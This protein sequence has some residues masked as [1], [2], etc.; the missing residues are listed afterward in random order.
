MKK[1]IAL[2]VLILITLSAAN[3]RPIIVAH[4]CGGGLAP[5]NTVIA[6]ENAW[7]AGADGIEIDV[8]VTKDG[9]AV[10]LHDNTLE[11]YA[12]ID[13]KVEDATFGQL[14]SIDLGPYFGPQ[15]KNLKIPTLQEILKTVPKG[16]FAE[17]DMKARG[18]RTAE[19][20]SACVL[21][22]NAV[23]RVIIHTDAD[24]MRCFKA[25]MPTVKC[26]GG[27]HPWNIDSEKQLTEEL[28]YLCS[29]FNG[30]A[31]D[32][33]LATKAAEAGLKTWAWTIDDLDRAKLLVK[34][35]VSGIITNRP[36]IMLKGLK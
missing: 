10:I 5:E 31:E 19:I 22:E 35:G 12:G 16:K 4:R 30:N 18:K 32:P 3:G 27:L 36:D 28:G 11:R 9:K 13:L 33:E 8:R 6:A 1:I 25:I 17:F 2:A 20:V 26:I 21:A 7:K 29:I 34:C 14:R 24:S 23:D 15:Y